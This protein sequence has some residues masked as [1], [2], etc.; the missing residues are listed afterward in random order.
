[1]VQ[2]DCSYN[3]GGISYNGCSFG[4]DSNGEWLRQVNLTNLGSTT[5][6][7]NSTITLNLILSNGW[8]NRAF[9]SDSLAFHVCSN[10]DAYLSQGIILL[11]TLINSPS[12]TVVPVNNLTLTQSNTLAGGSSNNL[13]LTFSINV[14]TPVGTVFMLGLPKSSY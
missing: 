11:T 10:A 14:P 12:F 13:S 9:G 4:L 8:T 1:V 6:P 3:I 7:A 2:Q 5:I